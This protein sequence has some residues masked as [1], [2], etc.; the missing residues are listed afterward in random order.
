MSVTLNAA[1]RRKL[2][3]RFLRYVAVDTQSDDDSTTSP[4]TEKQK[5]L[6]R[7]LAEELRALGCGDAAMN[8]WGYVVATV[9]GNLPGGPPGGGRGARPSG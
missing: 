9:P 1:D 4:S 5:D 6:S 2:L 8:E 3:E 7:M